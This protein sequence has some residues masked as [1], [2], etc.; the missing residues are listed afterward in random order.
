MPIVFF[1]V[2]FKVWR[3]FKILDLLSSGFRSSSDKVFG[4]YIAYDREN[5]RFKPGIGILTLYS[6]YHMIWTNETN[7]CFRR[8]LP[9]FHVLDSSIQKFEILNYY[10]IIF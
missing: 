8:C 1:V 3:V 7:H 4:M 9:C 5:N 2:R 10:V 6:L